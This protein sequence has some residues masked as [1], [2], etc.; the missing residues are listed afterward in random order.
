MASGVV[1]NL[2]MG[3]GCGVMVPET[4]FKKLWPM[5]HASKQFLNII[6]NDQ[7]S[8]CYFFI[9]DDL[10]GLDNQKCTVTFTIVCTQ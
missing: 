5:H 6:S 8:P 10:R 2:G 4:I 7:R 3:C 9:F 1:Y